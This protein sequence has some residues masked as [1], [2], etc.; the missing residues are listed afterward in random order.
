MCKCICSHIDQADVQTGK[1]CLEFYYLDQSI[2]PEDK[3]SSVKT[4]EGG[5]DSFNTFRENDMGKHVPQAVFVDLKLKVI[6]EVHTGT[7]C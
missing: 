6:D 3:M 2:Q 5:D 1:A 4:T 7:Y